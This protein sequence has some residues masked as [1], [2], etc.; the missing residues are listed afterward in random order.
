MVDAG[1]AASEEIADEGGDDLE[2]VGGAT[3][4]SV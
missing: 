1:G 4:A 3:L 2:E